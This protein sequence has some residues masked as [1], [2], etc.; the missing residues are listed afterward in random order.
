MLTFWGK[1]EYD[2]ESCQWDLCPRNLIV[3]VFAVLLGLCKQSCSCLH[4]LLDGHREWFRDIQ[5]VMPTLQ[6]ENQIL[7]RI[8]IYS[9]LYS[10]FLLKVFYLF[11]NTGQKSSLAM[12]L[13]VARV[14]PI[15]LM[16]FVS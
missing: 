4:I 12:L 1:Q 16:G 3:W 14:W 10:L 5:I 11:W 2:G 9:I 15:V 13:N 7:R 8:Y 6:K